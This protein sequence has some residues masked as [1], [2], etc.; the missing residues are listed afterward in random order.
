[1][2]LADD[3][4]ETD[5][6][7]SLALSVL[8]GFGIRGLGDT[9]EMRIWGLWAPARTSP[10][11]CGLED[12]GAML[13]TS[14]EYRRYYR[15]DMTLYRLFVDFIDESQAAALAVRHEQD[16]TSRGGAGIESG[17]HGGARGETKMFCLGP[18]LGSSDAQRSHCGSR[19]EPFALHEDVLMS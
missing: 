10:A 17:A 18:A 14:L 12:L 9:W 2:K 15:L 7:P 5:S 3:V 16:G 11:R 8:F 13:I 4:N 1:M 19:G 6:W